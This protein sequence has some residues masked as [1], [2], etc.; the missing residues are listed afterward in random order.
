MLAL[1][2]SENTWVLRW[3]IS[4]DDWIVVDGEKLNNWV[5]VVFWSEVQD[6]MERYDLKWTLDI[7]FYTLDKLNKYADEKQ[8][9][10]LIKTDEQA[11]REVL[12]ILAEWLRQVW[13]CLYPFFPEKMSEMFTKLGLK[14]YKT[15]LEAGK[16]NELLEKSET[17]TITEKG[18]PL[19]MRQEVE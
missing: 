1:K 19:F 15:Q 10:T 18:S 6:T 5:K 7:A 2:L 12:Y 13:L 3:K 14:D 9:W 16:L 11:T 8:P 4:I 17:F